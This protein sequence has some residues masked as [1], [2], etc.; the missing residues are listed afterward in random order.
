MVETL[1]IIMFSYDVMGSFDSQ[2]KNGDGD[3]DDVMML[4]T[5]IQLTLRNVQEGW[6][7]HVRK[8]LS[9]DVDRFWLR[10]KDSH[11]RLRLCQR[12]NQKE[13]SQVLGTREDKTLT[14]EKKNHSHSH[15]CWCELYQFSF[16][17]FRYTF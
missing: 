14:S 12:P 4:S 1:Q 9:L 8:N 7:H 6:F 17:C 2:N 15:V 11:Q 3:D 16:L 10:L 13:N 5:R